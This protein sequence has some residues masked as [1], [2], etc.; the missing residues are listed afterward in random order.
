MSDATPIGAVSYRARQ[1]STTIPTSNGV[2]IEVQREYYWIDH[3]GNS[4]ERRV[5]AVKGEASAHASSYPAEWEFVWSNDDDKVVRNFVS[6]LG[7]NLGFRRNADLE[8]SCQINP[9]LMLGWR[10]MPAGGTSHGYAVLNRDG[11]AIRATFSESAA[12]ISLASALR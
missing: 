5:V 6:E 4:K 12:L 9:W 8:I 1:S 2:V 11:Y 10:E 7:V 3:P